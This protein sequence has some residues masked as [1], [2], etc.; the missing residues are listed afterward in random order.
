MTFVY[1]VF[2][3][4]IPFFLYNQA[5]RHIP[6]GIASLFLVLVIPLGFLFAAIFM[7]EEITLLKTTGAVLVM[8]GVVLPHLLQIGIKRYGI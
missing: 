7:G 8:I 5:M 4:A 6:V 2:S 3:L 1:L